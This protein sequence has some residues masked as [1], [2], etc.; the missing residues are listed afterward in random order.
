MFLV[1][2]SSMADPAADSSVPL[3]KPPPLFQK[4]CSL[5]HANGEGNPAMSKMLHTDPAIMNL[6][7]SKLSEDEIHQL[8]KSGRKRMPSFAYL[9]A[10]E[11]N[12]VTAFVLKLRTPAPQKNPS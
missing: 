6:T 10:D 3:V 8:L 12:E 2:G 7:Q 1:G 11:A 4:K 9:S 5:C